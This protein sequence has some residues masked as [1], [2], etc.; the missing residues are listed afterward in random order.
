MSYFSQMIGLTVQN[1]LSA[2]TG[3]AIA[4]VVICA[5]ARK[6]AKTVG[7]FW[8]DMTRATLGLLL[9]GAIIAAVF[10]I[11]QGMPQ[12]PTPTPRRQHWRERSR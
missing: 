9:P 5:F 7:N 2:A 1:F 4:L 3:I 12:N 11:W 6:S 8:T 10:L